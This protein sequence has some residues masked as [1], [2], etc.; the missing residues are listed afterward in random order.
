MCP[1]FPCIQGRPERR[2]VSQSD[3]ERWRFSIHPLPKNTCTQRRTIWPSHKQPD[4]KSK[5]D[6]AARTSKRN[7]S[8]IWL[9]AIT[10]SS[11]ALLRCYWGVQTPILRAA[12]SNSGGSYC[13]NISCFRAL[14][15]A[16]RAG[17]ARRSHR[18]RRS[19]YRAVRAW[20]N[21]R[22]TCI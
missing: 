22:S 10:V 13:S 18:S 3:R 2:K 9:R 14:V 11:N 8:R 5:C 21:C 4:E 15:T 6:A 1:A 12:C 16:C 7:P 17:C 20:K 19:T